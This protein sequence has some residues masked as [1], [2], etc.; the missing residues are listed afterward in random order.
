MTSEI[1][2]AIWT[3]LV[4]ECGASDL[5]D[6]RGSFVYYATTKDWITFRFQ[7]DLGLEGKVN[8]GPPTG[9]N[10]SHWQVSYSKEDYSLERAVKEEL[11]NRRLA[12]LWAESQEPKPSLPVQLMAR[13]ERITLVAHAETLGWDTTELPTFSD[14]S[15][16]QHM[17]RGKLEE[18]W[19]GMRYIQCV[20]TAPD[21]IDF[22]T[23]P[24]AAKMILEV[25]R[26]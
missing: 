20:Y 11:A 26:P 14:G 7:G 1:A 17:T 25:S 15:W 8:R 19:I 9:Y 5:P 2:N 4:E 22:Y 21:V 13:Q 23:D 6:S 12:T 10:P 16:Y 3:I 24:E 18:V